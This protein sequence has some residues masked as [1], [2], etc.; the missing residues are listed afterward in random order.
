MR[1]MP[2]AAMY[3]KSRDAENA[4]YRIDLGVRYL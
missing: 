4:I 3:R 2:E 1:L